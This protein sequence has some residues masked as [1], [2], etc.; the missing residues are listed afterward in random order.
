MPLLF[1]K[2]IFTPSL[3]FNDLFFLFSRLPLIIRARNNK[4][5]SKAFSEKIMNVVTAVNGCVYCAWF[6]AKLAVSSGISREEVKNLMQLQFQTD[7]TDYELPALLF[8]QHYAETNRRPEPDMLTK[9]ESFYGQ[10]NAS[11]ILLYIRL[12]FFGNLY[13]NTFDAFLSRFK[14]RKP[15]KGNLVFEFLFFLINAPILLP[16]IPFVKKFRKKV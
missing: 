3:F 7:A 13:G 15:E 2:K 16:I 5:I 6:H 12:I 11:H 4:N 14:G 9:I 1:T 8:A 10:K